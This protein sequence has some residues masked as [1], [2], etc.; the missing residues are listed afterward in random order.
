LNHNKEGISATI[1][2]TNHTEEY[3]DKDAVNGIA[4]KVLERCFDDSRVF[5]E[6]SSKKISF[7]EGEDGNEKTE[8]KGTSDGKMHG[9]FYA[10]GFT[11]REIL[12]HKGCDCLHISRGNQQDKSA[13]FTADT[14]SCRRN[15]VK[16]VCYHLNHRKGKANK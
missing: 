5:S 7:E 11:G 4:F 1:E 10:V 6:D 8:S 2:I 9:F 14:N 15:H 3:G 12:I 16:T 13:K